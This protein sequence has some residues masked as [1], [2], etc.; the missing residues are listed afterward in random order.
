MPGEGATQNRKPVLYIGL[1]CA[2][3]RHRSRLCALLGAYCLRRHS[4]LVVFTT[5]ADERVHDQCICPAVPCPN[6]RNCV[7]YELSQ[8]NEDAEMGKHWWYIKF[9]N[10]HVFD[11]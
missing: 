7:G 6:L 1:R 11:P 9:A 8:W 5:A 3:G 2:E 4:G 10:D